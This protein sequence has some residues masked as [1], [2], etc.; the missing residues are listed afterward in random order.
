MAANFCW[1]V[2]MPSSKVDRCSSSFQINTGYCIDCSQ[3]GKRDADRHVLH[4]CSQ[5]KYTEKINKI[6]VLMKVNAMKKMGWWEAYIPNTG[7]LMFVYN[8]SMKKK[9]IHKA[10]IYCRCSH[11]WRASDTSGFDLRSGPVFFF[12]KHFLSSLGLVSQSSMSDVMEIL[13]L[14]EG[15]TSVSSPSRPAALLSGTLAFQ[16]SFENVQ[17][18]IRWSPDAASVCTLLVSL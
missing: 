18:Y 12:I 2:R 8:D 9:G 1:N 15:P 4:V 11:M 3:I 14:W 10:K 6:K 7:P 17:T 13:P 16:V 5:W